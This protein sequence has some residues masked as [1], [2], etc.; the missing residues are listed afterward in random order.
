[1]RHVR[2][3]TLLAVL[4]AAAI[5]ASCGDSG[6][7]PYPVRTY[8]LGERIPLGHIIYQIYETQWLTHMGEG[9]EARVPENRFFLVRLSA[10]NSAGADVIVPNFTVEDDSG[11]SY[12][13]LS[14]AEGVP[15]YIG[16][17]RSVKPAESVTGNALFDAPPRHYRLKI[18]DE[19]GDK[20]AYVDI[21][22]TFN[23]ETPDVPE[24]GGKD[25]K[26]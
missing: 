2:F 15:Q 20:T 13:E 17:L 1:M 16:Y 22:L 19:T 23:S 6:D 24:V 10:V 3:C 21:P 9:A 5:L 11:K 26:K 4:V 8:N 7:K 14:T 25:K 18:Q 12:A